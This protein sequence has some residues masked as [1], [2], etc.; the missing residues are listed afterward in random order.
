MRV[1][2]RPDI[3]QALHETLA[4]AA[5]VQVAKMD[6]LE[7]G[8]VHLVRGIEVRIGRETLLPR[9]LNDLRMREPPTLRIR[10]DV[11]FKLAN[12]RRELRGQRLVMI[13]QAAVSLGILLFEVL[14]L[15]RRKSRVVAVMR[16]DHLDLVDAKLLVLRGL[17]LRNGQRGR[18]KKSKQGSCGSDRHD[19]GLLVGVGSNVQ[20]REV[21]CARN[22]IFGTSD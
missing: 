22:G 15:A 9:D 12:P 3:L 16:A 20:R 1:R 8:L 2:P 10:D 11:E 17:T 19:A 4:A 7:P 14:R 18:R 21:L 6:D 13:F 5:L